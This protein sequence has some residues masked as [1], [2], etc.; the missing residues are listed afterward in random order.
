MAVYSISYDFNPNDAV[1]VVDNNSVKKSTCLQVDI[2]VV[3]G[4]N[5]TITNIIN[6]L[7]LLDCNAGTLIVPA[8][9]VFDSLEDAIVALQSSIE[10]NTC[11]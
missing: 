11:N 3:P 10:N 6:Y 4:I 2:K 1:W 8:E 5:N 9:N 7:V